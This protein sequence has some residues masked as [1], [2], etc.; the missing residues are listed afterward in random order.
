MEILDFG[1]WI[2]EHMGVR[3]RMED[4]IWRIE[5]FRWKD[6]VRERGSAERL[7]AASY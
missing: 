4:G 5:Y 7:D 3:W 2:V 1:F 6:G